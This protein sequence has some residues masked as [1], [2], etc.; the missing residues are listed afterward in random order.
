MCG[1]VGIYSKEKKPVGREWIEKMI[2]SIRHRGTDDE[3]VKM[4]SHAGF[5][6]RRL[7]IIDI[8]GG[9]QPM[10]DFRNTAWI[11]FNG[12]I[13][14]YKDLRVQLEESGVKFKTRSDTEV[15]INLIVT[16][17]RESICKLNGMFGFAYYKPE[18]DYVLLARDHLGIKPVYYCE[19]KGWIAFASEIKALL[20][21]PWVKFGV[22]ESLL[23]ELLTF[24]FVT[25]NNTL[26]KGIYQLEPGEYLEIENGIILKGKFWDLPQNVSYEKISIGN[27]METLDERLSSSV[28]KQL[29]ADVPV[30]SFLSGG[31]D[32]GI[33]TALSSLLKKGKGRL[34]TFVVGFDSSE[35]DERDYAH[36]TTMRYNTDHHE[37]I[38]T[39]DRILKDIKKLTY[40]NDEPISHPNT[41]PFY[42]LS[43][44]AH[45]NV[46]VVL[47]GEGADE[48]L[49]GYPRHQVVRLRHKAGSMPVFLRKALGNILFNFPNRKMKMIGNGL[50]YDNDDDAL[51]FNSQFVPNEIVNRI[52]LKD[53]PRESLTHRR[54]YAHYFKGRNLHHRLMALEVKTYLLS[55]LHRLDRMSM[56]HGLECRVPFLDY[57]LVEWIMSL[58][59]NLKVRGKTGKFILKRLAEKYIDNDIIYRPKSGF[60][61]PLADWFRDK[62][63]LRPFLN[64]LASCNYFLKEYFDQKIIK[65]MVKEHL[66]CH[67]DYSELFWILLCLH[68][69]Y[70]VFKYV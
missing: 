27:A 37:Y 59:P 28:E 44:L 30:G 19:T 47:T 49:S 32:S 58:R 45:E 67:V 60:G 33:V 52:L 18:D 17:G 42:H 26:F 1:F 14:N 24:R 41:I 35:W 22:E 51:V 53:I 15:L 40:Y 12:E 5:G 48:M 56:A 3:G 57:Q 70:D 20:T 34:K 13:Y 38:M 54:N 7:S 39:A 61:L 2:N 21:L 11:V 69:W 23:E 62:N 10:T 8:S 29:I 68:S 31:V 65:M 16:F 50:L 55:A 64:E 46:K 4:F 43:K 36:R 66:D 6:H 25:G 9:K 63:A